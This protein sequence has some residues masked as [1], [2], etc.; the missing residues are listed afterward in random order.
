MS[1]LVLEALQDIVKES[2]ETVQLLEL[3]QQGVQKLQ[4][5]AKTQRSATVAPSVIQSKILSIAPMETV[6]PRLAAANG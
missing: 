5:Q 6:C 1:K 3:F 2:R 4:A